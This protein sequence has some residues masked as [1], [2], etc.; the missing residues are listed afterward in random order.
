MKQGSFFA[1][2]FGQIAARRI[3]VYNNTF[4]SDT[5]PAFGLMRLTGGTDELASGKAWLHVEEPT[6]DS[7]EPLLVNSKK[8]L[9]D[10]SLY[11]H[12]YTLYSGPVWIAYNSAATPSAGQTWGP[13]E[14]SFLLDEDGDGFFILDVNS[15]DELALA[16]YIHSCS[17]FWEID[18]FPGSAPPSS[19]TA[20]FNVTIDA[21]SQDVTI[22]WDM[23]AAELTTE[24][25]AEFSGLSS[26]DIDVTGGPL[27]T[28]PLDV[29]WKG[30]TDLTPDWPPT[31]GASTLNNSSVCKIR[32]RNPRGS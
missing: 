3:A 1:P 19:G 6:G 23:T 31:V 28:I 22:E 29:E 17:Y 10:T 27:P 14:D 20:I 5:I 24:L 2:G 13:V 9:T 4:Y 16:M 21:D 18:I 8:P 12:G 7:G 25:L 15:T 30:G 32:Q 11:G 26:A